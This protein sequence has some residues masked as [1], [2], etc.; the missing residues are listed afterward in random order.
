M[1]MSMNPADT[2]A[3]FARFGTLSAVTN[4]D[5]PAPAASA[6]A[7]AVAAPAHATP[8]AA[9]RP[10]GAK[11]TQAGDVHAEDFRPTRKVR[12]REHDMPFA[13]ARQRA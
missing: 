3:Q 1:S 9:P 4:D 11:T 10:A 13:V 5:K 6:P 2:P 8:D 12:S 7:P